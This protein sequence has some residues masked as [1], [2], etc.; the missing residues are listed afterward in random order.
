MKETGAHK[1]YRYSKLAIGCG[2]RVERFSSLT[3]LIAGN[4]YNI[5]TSD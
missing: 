4:P 5:I 1:A 3:R 2:H